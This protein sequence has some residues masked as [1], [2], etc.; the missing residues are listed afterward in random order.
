M[1]VDHYKI[2]L[3]FDGLKNLKKQID[4]RPVSLRVEAEK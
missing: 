3:V 2:L 1:L 4:A